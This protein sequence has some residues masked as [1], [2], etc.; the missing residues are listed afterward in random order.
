MMAC[1]MP[2][3]GTTACAG[4]LVPEDEGV[5]AFCCTGRRRVRP[6]PP[7]TF[8]SS[9]APLWGP[10]VPG[11]WLGAHCDRS[12]GDA[13]YPDTGLNVPSC[14]ARDRECPHIHPH[15]Q[16]E[17]DPRPLPRPAGGDWHRLRPDKRGLPV[18]YHAPFKRWTYASL[19]F[20]YT[21]PEA[22]PAAI[23]GTGQLFA[24]PQSI[25]FPHRLQ[26]PPPL[27]GLAPGLPFR[28]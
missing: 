28:R 17:P 2:G 8:P 6:D 16:P 9:P 14:F 10:R 23:A 12:T 26:Q 7:L 13:P 25:G 1:Q 19:G 27:R 22:S 24:G 5:S 4:F 11:P 3:P 20:Q 15:S 18:D 21:I